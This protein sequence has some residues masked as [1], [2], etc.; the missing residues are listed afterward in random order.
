M[1]SDNNNN[2][3]CILTSNNWKSLK[4]KVKSL[5]KQTN[6]KSLQDEAKR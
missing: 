5:I 6:R 1:M 3:S 4:H 2:K